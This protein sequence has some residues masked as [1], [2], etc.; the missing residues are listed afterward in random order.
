MQ[1]A[2]DQARETLEQ[3]EFPVGCVMEYQGRVVATGKR[4]NSSG[5][6]NELDHAEMIALR[7]LLDTDETVDMGR[8]TVYCTLEPCLMCFST[9]LVNG[10]RNIVYSYEDA[11][12]GGTALD[13]ARLTPLYQ[14]M[15]V[16]VTG[17][18]MRSQSLELFRIFFATPGNDYL[19]GTLLAEYTL[20]QLVE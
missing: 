1:Q 7:Q 10:I 8:V 19:R 3:G 9:L 17:G 6:P 20:D 2:L 5:R 15:D 12:G 18:V 4:R 13:L 14:E 16:V 11:M